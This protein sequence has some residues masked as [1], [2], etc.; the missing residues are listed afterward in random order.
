MAVLVA[1]RA[2]PVDGGA[3][4]LGWPGVAHPPGDGRG[5]TVEGARGAP[6]P[7]PVSRPN[8]SRTTQSRT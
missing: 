8:A 1:D 2:G 4:T 3:G 6:P 5:S 7:Q